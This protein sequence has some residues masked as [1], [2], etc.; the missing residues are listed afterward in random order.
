[1]FVCHGNICRSPMAECIMQELVDER[2]LQD[3]IKVNSSAV[4]NEEIG[5]PIYNEAHEKLVRENIRIKEHKAVKFTS[6][7]YALN[8]FII[9]M[10]NSNIKYLMEIIKED[11]YAKVYRLLDFTGSKRDI[12]DPWYTRNFDVAYDEIKIGCEALLEYIIDAQL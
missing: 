12:L 10:D 5:N 9:C 2:N 11:K 3:K 6:E 8:D 4:S 7:D 1:M